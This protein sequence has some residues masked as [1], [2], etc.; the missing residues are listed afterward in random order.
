MREEDV[1]TFEMLWDCPYCGTKKLLGVSQRHCPSCGAAQDPAKRYFPSDEDKVAV[2]DHAF[3]GADLLCPYC[4]VPNSSKSAHCI[5]CGGDLIKAKEAMRRGEQVVAEGQSFVGENAADAKRD[6][7][8]Q[9]SGK[10]LSAPP[11]PPP[12]KSMLK[13][14]IVGGVVL[15]GI[16]LAVIFWRKP[17][18]VVAA[19]HRWERSVGVEQFG[20]TQL[21]EWC[22][23]LPLD[24][25]FVTRSREVRSHNKVQDGETCVRKR[26]DKGNGAFSERKE[27]TP[28]Y[29]DEPVYD[30]KCHFTADRWRALPPITAQGASLSDAPHWP[31]VN[32]K[33]GTC[34]G[35]QREAGRQEKYLVDFRR[36][37]DGKTFDCTVDATRWAA[38]KE[39]SKW[40]VNIG[41]LSGVADCDS[42]QSL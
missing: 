30:M 17:A 36:D 8:A 39:G 5:G 16:I 34:I 15:L 3:M 27:C 13:W 37:K 40:K 11:P 26:A 12:K 1:G 19:G 7:A 32:L 28:K 2:K 18:S 4:Q 33:T 41:A 38:I 31:S 10:P 20:P 6:F 24:A 22:N 42:L 29:R 25:H 23:Q 9:K 35:C 21:N 14:F